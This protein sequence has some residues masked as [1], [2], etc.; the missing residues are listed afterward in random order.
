MSLVLGVDPGSRH[1]G[2][3]MLDGPAVVAWAGFWTMRS[4]GRLVVSMSHHPAPRAVPSLHALGMAFALHALGMG[5]SR[6]R[7]V[8]EE[9]FVPRAGQAQSAQTVVALAE[10]CGE[11][12]G[13]LREG[14]TD[15]RRVRAVDWRHR[16]L[17]LAAR[18]PAKAAEEYAVRVAPTLFWWP[19]NGWS[20]LGA[21]SKDARGGVV[22][23]ACIARWGVGRSDVQS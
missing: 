4:S 3:V 14:A 22:E 19:G 21:M 10:A 11:L 8:V 23:A 12:S 17:G 15:V 2:L 9:L 18:T 6:W 20:D 7:L 5:M 1:G 16:V 13:P